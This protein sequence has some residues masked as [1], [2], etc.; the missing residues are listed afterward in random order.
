[1]KLSLFIAILLILHCAEPTSSTIV[2]TSGLEE[3]QNLGFSSNSTFELL[4]W[5]LENY[6]KENNVTKNYVA[7]IIYYTSPDVVALQEIESLGYFNSLID[8]LN[9]LDSDNLWIGFRAG[10]GSTWM[11]LAYVIKSNTVEITTEPFE[12]YHQQTKLTCLYIFL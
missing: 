4:T 8:K 10:G 5:N 3:L 9:E 6:P 11:E 2:E 1:M 12:I 7:D